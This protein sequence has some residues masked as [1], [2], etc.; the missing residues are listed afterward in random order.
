MVIF[1]PIDQVGCFKACATVTLAISLAGIW[2]N[3]PPEAVRMIFRTSLPLAPC[4]HWKMALCSLSTGKTWRFFL[5]ASPMTAEPA[6][7]KISLLATAKSL[8]Q[9]RAA[10]AG[11]KP[12]VPTMA[13]STISASVSSTILVRPSGPSNSRAPLGRCRRVFSAALGSETASEETPNSLA[14][15]RRRA[16][17]FATPRPTSFILSGKA[18]ATLQVLSPMEPL[19]P[20]RMTRFIP[21]P[22]GSDTRKTPEG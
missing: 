17:L 8:P 3:G 11:A 13:T 1:L 7:T 12:A 15:S 9:R 6:K 14:C 19:E 18:F 22:P 16:V 4:R 2:R 20:S 10:K 21:S 5:L